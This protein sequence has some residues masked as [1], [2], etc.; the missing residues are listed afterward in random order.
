MTPP[1]YTEEDLVDGRIVFTGVEGFS[2][3]P[4]GWIPNDFIE[5]LRL[6]RRLES[7]LSEFEFVVGAVDCEKKSELAKIRIFA[8][9]IELVEGPPVD[10]PSNSEDKPKTSGFDS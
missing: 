4:T 8:R 10:R 6:V 2:M 9:V 5:S 3:E 7:G 1:F